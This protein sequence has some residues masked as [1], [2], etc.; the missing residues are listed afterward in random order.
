MAKKMN[1]FGAFQVLSPVLT[2]YAMR[3]VDYQFLRTATLPV[4]LLL[5]TLGCGGTAVAPPSIQALYPPETVAG[6]KFL[7]QGDGR[8][9]IAIGGKNFKPGAVVLFDRRP[10]ET[11][12]GS[13]SAVTASVPDELFSKPGTIQVRVENPDGAASDP[14]PFTV[15]QK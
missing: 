1:E 15:R 11:A 4:P 5:L 6:T 3:T 14:M 9:A 7:V 13:E 10:L 2:S 8:A 12:F